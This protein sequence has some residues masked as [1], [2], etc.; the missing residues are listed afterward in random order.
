MSLRAAAPGDAA[1]RTT[2]RRAGAQI[3]RATYKP[4]CDIR[5]RFATTLLSCP[6]A[7]ARMIR[8]RRAMRRRARPL[9]Q[10]VESHGFLVRQNQRLPRLPDPITSI[11]TATGL[12]TG[13][14]T[15]TDGNALSVRANAYCLS[16]ARVTP[17]DV[18]ASA[19]PPRGDPSRPDLRITSAGCSGV[20]LLRSDSPRELGR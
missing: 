11:P 7:H 9:G 1:R 15:A 18:N 3:S 5:S 10:R 8:A 19:T 13:L 14:V 17:V 20:R 2:R 12:F 4:C 6:S 16:C